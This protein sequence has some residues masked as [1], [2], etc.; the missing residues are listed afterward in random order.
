MLNGL[1]APKGLEGTCPVA[2]SLLN[3]IFRAQDQCL[4]ISIVGC[5]EKCPFQRRCEQITLRLATRY[6]ITASEQQRAMV[7]WRELQLQNVM[8]IGIMSIR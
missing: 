3:D 2:D 1:R 4:H 8:K 7:E 6:R 5:C